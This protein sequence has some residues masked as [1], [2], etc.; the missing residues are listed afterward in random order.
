MNYSTN[1]KEPVNLALKSSTS[2]YKKDCEV[3]HVSETVCA[4]KKKL[5]NGYASLFGLQM[6]LKK[7]SLIDVLFISL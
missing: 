7:S 4:I 1:L 6:K 5:F 3:S 2:S